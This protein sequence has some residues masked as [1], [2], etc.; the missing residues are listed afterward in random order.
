MN[1]L[2]SDYFLK[3]YKNSN[4]N[5]NDCLY[6]NEIKNNKIKE[7]NSKI[8][9]NENNK[10]SDSQLHPDLKID[11]SEI[12]YLDYYQDAKNND[13]K[14]KY[15]LANLDNNKKD[16]I[17]LN[18]NFHREKVESEIRVG[19]NQIGNLKINNNTL[20][21]IININSLEKL[22][23]IELNELL[24]VIR[25]INKDQESKKIY[26]DKI[27][28]KYINK[29]NNL[30]ISTRNYDNIIKTLDLEIDSTE[31]TVRKFQLE[32]IKENFQ[33][34]N[35]S[36]KT[37]NNYLDKLDVDTHLLDP[38]I[39]ASPSYK[40]NLSELINSIDNKNTVNIK[41]VLNNI[42]S[43]QIKVMLNEYGINKFIMDINQLNKSESEIILNQVYKKLLEDLHD[44]KL[45]SIV[46]NDY[47]SSTL[48]YYQGFK[49]EDIKEAKEKND[50]EN[51][52]LKKITE[53]C[54]AYENLNNK[55][56][57]PK[58]EDLIKVIKVLAEF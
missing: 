26:D 7:N 1:Q 44:S 12:N 2:S 17:K 56:K 20:S 19:L 28:G 18:N 3:L 9:L 40:A 42:K 45:Q 38:K 50:T 13:G 35:Y 37:V 39:Q 55:A 10:D 24:K 8:V 47:K 22:N 43:D 41:R 23:D 27:P 4:C 25:N 36:Y 29:L 5:C 11:L 30:A 46:K 14:A 15:S 54:L 32:S 52:K 31:D 58:G 49:I 6:E 48:S 21:D 16:N 51:R 34:K 57:Q 53:V 33:D